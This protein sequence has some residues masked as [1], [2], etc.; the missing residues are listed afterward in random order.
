LEHH[1]IN[2]ESMKLAHKNQMYTL[3]NGRVCHHYG[4]GRSSN[5]HITVM[6]PLNQHE[7]KNSNK[8][9]HFQTVRV[10]NLRAVKDAT[11]LNV[12]VA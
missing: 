9:A 6:I 2:G 8:T 5:S 7:K 12:K 1:F 3:P 11:I 10:S 4:P